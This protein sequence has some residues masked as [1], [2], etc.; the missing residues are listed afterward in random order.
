MSKFASEKTISQTWDRVWNSTSLQEWDKDFISQL[1]YATLRS[2]LK[3]TSNLRILE[4]GCGTGRISLR[5]GY[6]SPMVTL[7]DT[8]FSALTIARKF[9]QIHSG[10]SNFINNSIFNISLK[11]NSFDLV[12]NA[13]VL[14]HFL[15][16]E[17]KTILCEMLRVCKK[18]GK[19]IILV[20]YSKAVLYRM[21]K[22]F[23]EKL[24]SWKVGREVPLKTLKPL[25]PENNSLLLREYIVGVSEQTFLL[26]KGFKK[27][28]KFFLDSLISLGLSNFLMKVI[29]GYLLVS[30]IDK[31]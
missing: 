10:K 23:R 27:L 31:K 29:G 15:L 30:I 7:I 3:D 1:V 5:L 2:E 4:A 25:L 17:Q 12:W 13:G 11:N 6:E 9:S 21:G 14:E 20:P 16:Q 26:P 8:S 28:T 18:N 19:I 24:K 22:W